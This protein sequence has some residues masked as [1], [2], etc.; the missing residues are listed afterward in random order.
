MEFLIN[1][2]INWPS[3]LASNEI[4]RLSKAEREMAADLA[5]SGH[6]MRMWRVP[7]RRENW[8][9]WRASDP[10]E[11]H[12]IISSLPVWPYM[13]VK[14]HALAGHPVDPP[15]PSAGAAKQ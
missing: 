5:D 4:E 13:E 6:L 9:L 1:I 12:E 10:S 11:M 2:Q 3:N 7:G 15:L 14:V 8:G